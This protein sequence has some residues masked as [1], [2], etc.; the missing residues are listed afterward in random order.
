MFPK[1]EIGSAST[2]RPSNDNMIEQ[3]DLHERCRFGHTPRQR[4]VGIAG[5]RIARG[6]VVN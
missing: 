6:M 4:A 2:L 5:R 3:R 1:A